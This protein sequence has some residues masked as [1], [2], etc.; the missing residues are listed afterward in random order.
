RRTSMQAFVRKEIDDSGHV[1]RS[2]VLSGS[3]GAMVDHL[4]AALPPPGVKPRRLPC[5][6]ICEGGRDSALSRSTDSLNRPRVTSAPLL[7]ASPPR[8]HR[9]RRPPRG[10]AVTALPSRRGRGR[11]RSSS[12]AYPPQFQGIS[13]RR[14]P[15]PSDL[16]TK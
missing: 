6:P 5:R 3:G 9:L 14:P 13:R 11:R 1:T 16:P 4:G 7:S 10:Q 8:I 15:A 2:R 12:R